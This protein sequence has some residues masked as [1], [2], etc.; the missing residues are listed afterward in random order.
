MTIYKICSQGTVEEQMMGRI[1]KKL[2]L[3]AK[4]TESMKNIHNA[5]HATNNKK[6][7]TRAKRCIWQ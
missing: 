1:R 3:S 4:I 2:Y 5:D 7:K 6:R